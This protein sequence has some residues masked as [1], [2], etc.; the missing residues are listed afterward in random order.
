MLPLLALRCG[1]RLVYRLGGGGC[2]D[3]EKT[4]IW[5]GVIPLC[6]QPA[7]KAIVDFSVINLTVARAE[8]HGIDVGVLSG[9]FPYEFFKVPF[10]IPIAAFV[11]GVEQE[12]LLA[13]DIHAV[14]SDDIDYKEVGAWSAVELLQHPCRQALD[15]LQRWILAVKL[16]GLLDLVCPHDVSKVL[17]CALAVRQVFQCRSDVT[18]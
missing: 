10:L 8:C 12:M 14:P 6:F 16:V 17:D 2:A 7:C 4:W 15:L 13:T 3:T 5:S 1:L 9:C 18:N 11:V